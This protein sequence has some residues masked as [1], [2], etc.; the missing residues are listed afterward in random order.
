MA[1]DQ[2]AAKIERLRRWV[3]GQD[4][5]LGRGEAM[6]ILEEWAEHNARAALDFFSTAPRFP[7]R[8]GA[9]AIP[10]AKI[11]RCEPKAVADWI[12][13]HFPMTE[14]RSEIA[15]TVVRRIVEESP[16][17]AFQQASVVDFN[18]GSDCFG[19]M[20]GRVAG[21][22]PR[23]ARVGENSGRVDKQCRSNDFDW[24]ESVAFGF[25]RGRFQQGSFLGGETVEP[26]AGNFFQEFV[27]VIL[28]SFPLSG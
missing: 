24:Y 20:L 19:E 10:L 26:A 27:H 22:R 16:L 21:I 2:L 14:D 3:C 8:N 11:C 9:Y 25:G 23:F 28:L 17:A 5:S 1:E 15:E 12:M 7:R 13:H 18:G 6:K 4:A